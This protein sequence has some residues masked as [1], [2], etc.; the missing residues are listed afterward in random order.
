MT[1]T[2]RRNSTGRAHVAR[3][4]AVARRELAPF[5]GASGNVLYSGASTLRAGAVYILGLNPGGDPNQLRW[6]TIRRVLDEL[7]SKS[8]NEYL[9]VSW[10]G[11]EAGESLLQRRV[12]ALADMLGVELRDVCASNLIFMRSKDA[13]DCGYPDLA[14]ACWPVH[15]AILDIVRPRLVV[16]FGNSGRSPYAFLR[17]E[18]GDPEETTF[19]SGHGEWQCRIF[20]SSSGPTVAGLPHLSYYAIDRHP[21]VGRRLRRL[22]R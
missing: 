2:A 5:T 18:F 22:L 12:R 16:C 21:E 1:T 20:R 15:Q 8:E 14:D 11:R 6:Q 13:N 7:P 19:P 3:V 4:V 17:R 9:D 10:Q